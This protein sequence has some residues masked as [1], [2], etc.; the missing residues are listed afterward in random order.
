MSKPSLYE[1][2]G[3]QVTVEEIRF[4]CYPVRPK[5]TVLGQL[6]RGMTVEQIIG[7]DVVKSAHEARKR[8][9]EAQKGKEISLW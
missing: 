5:S 1:H 4:L 9:H 6:R 2:N 7:T 8:G 3:K